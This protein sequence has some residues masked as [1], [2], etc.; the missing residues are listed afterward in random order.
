MTE[1]INFPE[2]IL[3]LVDGSFFSNL[4]QET[5]IIIAKKTKASVTVLHVVPNMALY[6]SL[7]PENI[8]TGIINEI[9][10]ANEKEGRKIISDAKSLFE[11]EGLEVDPMILEGDT[12]EIALNL[13]KKGYDLLIVGAQGKNEKR[14]EILGSVTKKVLTHTSIPTLVIKRACLIS[15][16]LVCVD[17][18]EN[19]IIAL[20]YAAKL[21]KGMNSN[22]TLLNV[23]E[24]KLYD[25]SPMTARE[26]GEL[27]ISHALLQIG[28][29]ELN[30]ERKV[31]FG[32]PSDVIVEVAEKGNCDLIIMGSR[33]LGTVKR[34]LIG[35]VSDDVSQKAGTSVLIIPWRK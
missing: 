17:G 2:R 29:P 6:I 31:E 8:P 27:V 20:D 34:F 30:I 26:G 28:K 19:S 3:V 1:R 25:L 13:S 33:G 32:I 10:D 5:A 9:L 15:N 12:A 21:G 4:A 16:L 22:I 14:P 24:R 18:S 35:S 7:Y 11:K 23:E